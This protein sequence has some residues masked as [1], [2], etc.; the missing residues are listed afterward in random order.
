MPDSLQTLQTRLGHRFHD[1]RLL[2]TA[3]THRS[4]AREMGVGEHN[5]R[6]ELLGDAVLGLIATETLMQRFPEHSEGRLT[7]VKAALVS[8]QGLLREA[9]AIGLGDHLRL[10]RA[11]ERSGGREKRT[12]L[13]DTVEAIIAAVYL[14][15]GLDAARA[16]IKRLGLREERLIEADNNLAGGN[17]K[18]TLQEILQG[19]GLALPTYS[20]VSEQGPPHQRSYL[21]RIEVCG[22]FTAEASGA[23]K[24]AAEQLAAAE[25]LRDLSWLPPEED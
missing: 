5:E 18:S 13:A 4:Y 25:A 1:P 6:L 8:T 23:T 20:V 15:G 3:L 14:D 22:H 19:R 21:I 12:L 9:E 16:V 7:K 11:E 24:K 10:G 2:E 17:P